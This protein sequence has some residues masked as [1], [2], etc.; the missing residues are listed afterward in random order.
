[1]AHTVLWDTNQ[2][3][4]STLDGAMVEKIIPGN[5]IIKAGVTVTVSNRCKGLHIQVMGNCFIYGTI[6][7]TAKGGN[8]AGQNVGL[9]FYSDRNKI[10][11]DG[12][13]WASLPTIRKIPA[14]GANGASAAGTYTTTETATGVSGNNGS[15]GTDG[16][17]GG[18]GS[19]AIYTWK[20]NG[21]SYTYP[22]G[23]A[24]SFSGGPGSG[25]VYNSSAP[26]TYG[27]A[28]GV[29]AGIG[30]GGYN[31]AGTAYGSGGG[32]GNPGGLAGG[33][34]GTNG[35]DGA[36]GL[37]ILSVLGYL[38]I[39]SSGIIRSNGKNGGYGAG[40]YG[41]YGLCG[42]GSGG[43]SINILYGV[44]TNNGTL[45]VNGG[46]GPTYITYKGG[47]GGAG[48]IRYNSLRTT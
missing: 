42:G 6:D 48:S 41:E 44:L 2:T 10:T 11:L 20:A 5:L 33:V 45:Q 34:G 21:Y 46:I 30:G 40:G 1:M 25:G 19:G 36:G 13:G 15:A 39:A 16:K 17:A 31:Y 14:V 32:A 35:E 12:A 23:P 9:E 26:G 3:F 24:T 7:M 29:N 18:G 27:T 28:P 47:D 37:L 8:I 38:Y 4:T 43:G 22:G